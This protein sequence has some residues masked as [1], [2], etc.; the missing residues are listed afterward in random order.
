MNYFG[1]L[2][3]LGFGAIE[4]YSHWMTRNIKDY[5]TLQYAHTGSMHLGTD[6]D[7]NVRKYEAPFAWLMYKKRYFRF[8]NPDGSRRYLGQFE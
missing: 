6:S 2:E 3:F 8:G 1:G 4:R 5:Y 7:E